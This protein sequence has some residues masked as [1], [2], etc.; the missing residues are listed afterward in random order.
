VK[1]SKELDSIAINFEEL[2]STHLFEIH[3]VSFKDSSQLNFF[4]A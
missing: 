1:V 3:E 2:I 4:Q